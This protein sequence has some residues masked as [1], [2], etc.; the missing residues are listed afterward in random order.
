M[1]IR[2]PGGL[3]VEAQHEGFT[4]LTDQPAKDGGTNTAPSPFD[5][6]LVSLGTCSGYYALRFCQERGIPTEGLSLSLTT[7]RDEARK[8][9]SKIRIE[10]R[11]PGGFPEKYRAAIL[12]AADQCSVKRYLLDPPALEVVTIPA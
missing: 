8:R 2:F 4:I 1:E 11:L 6:F 3:L 12:R 5:L 9:Y 7:E 10:I